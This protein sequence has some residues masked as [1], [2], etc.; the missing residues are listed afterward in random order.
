LLLKAVCL[1]GLVVNAWMIFGARW[2]KNQP[3]A[4]EIQASE[5]G[6]ELPHSKEGKS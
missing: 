5:S 4:P 1:C 2:R 6:N 3:V